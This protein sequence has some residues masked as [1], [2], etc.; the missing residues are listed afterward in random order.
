MTYSTSGT[1]GTSGVNGTGSV[2]FEG[3]TDGTLTTGSPFDLGR[4]VVN[5]AIEG[6][7][8][9]YTD[10]PFTVTFSVLTVNGS[11]PLI[12]DSPIVISGLLNGTVTSSSQDDLSIYFYALP[13]PIDK[14]YPFPAAAE[15]FKV[16]NLINY[17]DFDHVQ[18]T[19]VDITAGL[20]VAQTVPEPSVLATFGCIVLFLFVRR[21]CLLNP[22]S[23]A[24]LCGIIQ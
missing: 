7:S 17:L 15:P 8:T 10:T 6:S 20:N 24:K 5:T 14:G 2:S 11:V 16:D 4:F 13:I 19:G 22:K 12:N 1:I 3:V 23:Q 21:N 18:S 9:T